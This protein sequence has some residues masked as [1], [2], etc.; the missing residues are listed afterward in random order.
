MEKKISFLEIFILI[1]VPSW[2]KAQ[3]TGNKILTTLKCMEKVANR[4]CIYEISVTR[5]RNSFMEGNPHNKKTML[6]FDP[7]ISNF[8]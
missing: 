5:R 6:I 7:N 3:P 8:G 4:L 1:R 2:L